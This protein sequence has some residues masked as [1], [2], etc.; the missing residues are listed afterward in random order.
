MGNPSDPVWVD[1]NVI[2]GI[3]NGDAGYEASLNAQK[4]AGHKL[5][6]P[7]KAYQ[8][9]LDGN[10]LTMDPKRPVQAQQPSPANK[11]KLVQVMQRL[12]VELRFGGRQSSH[13]P[14]DC[15]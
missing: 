3:G 12:G 11:A 15:R 1:A 4:A 10:P 8:E 7:P 9:V 13:V 14:A 6:I 2:A 5:L